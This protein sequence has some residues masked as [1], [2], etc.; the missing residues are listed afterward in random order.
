ML[1]RLNT[2]RQKEP[3]ICAHHI[4]VA[5]GT[6]QLEFSPA[7][8]QTSAPIVQ[9]I[10]RTLTK[11]LNAFYLL[12]K[13][14]ANRMDANGTRHMVSSPKINILVVSAIL[15]NFQK[16]LQK[17]QQKLIIQNALERTMTNAATIVLAKDVNIPTDGTSFNKCKKEMESVPH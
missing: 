12:I 3:L 13:A 2:A 17:N 9:M 11:L 14:H 4:W 10:E 15:P 5:R 1:P 8:H 7:L 16:S 6:N